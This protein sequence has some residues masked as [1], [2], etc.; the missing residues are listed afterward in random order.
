MLYQVSKNQNVLNSH[1]TLIVGELYQRNVSVLSS[2]SVVHA[3]PSQICKCNSNTNTAQFNINIM[4]Y[5]M[6][7]CT[8][9]QTGVHSDTGQ[10][11]ASRFFAAKN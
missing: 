6:I 1:S 10:E 8:A 11:G 9:G 4:T 2:E 3:P 7:D 5:I